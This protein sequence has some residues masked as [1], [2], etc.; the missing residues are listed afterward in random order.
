MK[1]RIAVALIGWNQIIC[2]R[3]NLSGI[4]DVIDEAVAMLPPQIEP[5]YCFV[6]D[7]LGKGVV[8]YES[9]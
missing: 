4:E 9:E 2:E 8:S 1:R 3:L 7:S 5:Y 6:G